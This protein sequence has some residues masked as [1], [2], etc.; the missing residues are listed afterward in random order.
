MRWLPYDHYEIGSTYL[1][2][3]LGSLLLAL[4]LDSGLR[5][6]SLHDTSVRIL[7]VAKVEELYKNIQIQT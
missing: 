1:T 4:T 3:D 6:V 7:G 2:S 5:Y